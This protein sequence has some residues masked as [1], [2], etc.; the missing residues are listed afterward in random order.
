MCS[1]LALFLILHVALYH[2]VLMISLQAPCPVTVM[3]YP[4][5]APF[6]ARCTVVIDQLCVDWFLTSSCC[7]V[8]V[9]SPCKLHAQGVLCSAVSLIVSITG[10]MCADI[11]DHIHN[12]QVPYRFS[13]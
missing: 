4:L 10:T 1:S 5:L 11:C 2:T 13:L 12:L 9:N 8:N 7:V 3:W 6:A